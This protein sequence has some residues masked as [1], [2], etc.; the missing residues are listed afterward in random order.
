M[1][2]IETNQNETEGPTMAILRWH[3]AAD[4]FQALE[5]LQEEMNRLFNPSLGRSPLFGDRGDTMWTPAIDLYET[6]DDLVVKAELPG[7]KLED[8]N[9]SL[10]ENTLTIEG[11]RKHEEEVK[12][13]SFYRVERWHGRFFRSLDLP[14]MVDADKIQATYENGVLRVTLPKRPEVKPRQIKVQVA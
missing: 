2:N 6:K 10:R 3:R 8:I 11:E 14:T 13:D 7:L 12:D 9:V 5:G 1:M 4:P